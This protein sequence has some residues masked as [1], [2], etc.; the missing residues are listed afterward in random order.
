[1]NFIEEVQN[2]NF[3]YPILISFLSILIY[4][5]YKYYIRISNFSKILEDENIFILS[6]DFCKCVKIKLFGFTFKNKCMV[7]KINR[8]IDFENCENIYYLLS[9]IK[10]KCNFIIH[11]EGGSTVYSDF[12]PY[13]ICQQNIELTTYIPEYSLSAG[14]FIA[15]ASKNIYMNWYSCMG[16]VDTQI[17]YPNHDSDDEDC[18][19]TF[20]AKH[21]MEVTRKTNAVTKLRSMEAEGYHHDDLFIIK[22]MFKKKKQR[23]NIIKYFLETNNSHSIKYGPKDLKKFGLNVKIGIPDKIMNVFNEFKNIKKI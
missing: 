22:S 10:K 21:I 18:D 20:A 5:Y 13:I 1:M 6:N 7:C 15:L 11:T 9:K 4:H 8:I 3:A 19:E 14:S 2:Y 12:L 16:P 17:D 23:R